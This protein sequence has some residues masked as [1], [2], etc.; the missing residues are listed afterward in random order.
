MATEVLSAGRVNILDQGLRVGR[1]DSIAPAPEGLLPPANADLDGWAT[2][3]KARGFN[4]TEATALMGSHALI[5][6]QVGL[7]NTLWVLV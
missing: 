2:F 4:L 1:L 6:E 7:W 3:W 5:D